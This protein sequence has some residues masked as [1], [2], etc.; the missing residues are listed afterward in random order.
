M[1]LKRHTVALH[2][3]HA[4]SEGVVDT[5]TQE[6]DAEALEAALKHANSLLANG[7]CRNFGC[8]IELDGATIVYTL[9][10][11]NCRDL[12]PV[13]FCRHDAVALAQARNATLA[14]ETTWRVDRALQ[15]TVKLPSAKP[16]SLP[17]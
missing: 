16:R 9:V 5:V 8:R 13:R 17:K 4:N 2:H 7:L 12:G 3:R 11:D 6:V 15:P 10:R 1:A 14:F